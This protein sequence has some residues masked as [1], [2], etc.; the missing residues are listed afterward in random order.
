MT[1]S[2]KLSDKKFTTA[3]LGLNTW[4]VDIAID[5]NI[6]GWINETNFLDLT[7]DLQIIQ[8]EDKRLS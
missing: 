1:S 3:Q 7:Y 5:L 6:S 2:C 8:R 4:F